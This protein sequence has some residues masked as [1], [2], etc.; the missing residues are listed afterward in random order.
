MRRMLLWFAAVVLGFAVPPVVFASPAHALPPGV[1]IQAGFAW[2]A[3]AYTCGKSSCVTM[4]HDGNFVLYKCDRYDRQ[5]CEQDWGQGRHGPALWATNTYRNSPPQ[6]FM[7]WQTDHNLVLYNQQLG[8][9]WTTNTYKN[10][11]MLILQDDGNFVIYDDNN[12]YAVWASNT[13]W[14]C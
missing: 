7:T 13:A 10:A 5:F 12:T 9:I 14:C 1:R 3:G 4:Q 6:F 2:A 8:V 11:R